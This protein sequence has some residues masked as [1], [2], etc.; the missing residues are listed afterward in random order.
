MNKKSIALLSS[1]L[2]GA[3]IIGGAFA[4]ITRW[5]VTDNANPNTAQITGGK[6]GEDTTGY[7]TL[8]WGTGTQLD[9]VEDMAD[10]KVYRVGVVNLVTDEMD[11]SRGSL[12][13][14]LQTAATGATKL[15]DY[16]EV[17][18]YEGEKD[19]GANNTYPEGTV[20]TGGTISPQH[21]QVSPDYDIAP[22]VTGKKT[23]QKYTIFVKLNCGGDAPTYAQIKNDVVYVR[24]DWN[25]HEDDVSTSNRVYVAKPAGWG[26]TFNYFAW[27]DTTHTATGDWPGQALTVE[28]KTRSGVQ[29]YYADIATSF[30]GFLFNDGTNQT[31]NIALSG[32]T[33]AKPAI[34]ID[35]EG[36]ATWIALPELDGEYEYRLIGDIGGV[37]HADE[38]WA[39]NSATKKVFAKTSTA[40]E[41][42]LTETF[43][44][45][46]EVKAVGSDDSGT[47]VLWF[48]A[49][50]GNY[51]ITKAG[52][53]NVYFRPAG[54]SDWGYYYLYFEFV[55]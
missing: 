16:L 45:N 36:K 5:A 42:K 39:W 28:S 1:V 15:V 20:I 50:G 55:A 6:L 46:D 49:E 31:E 10:G 11:Y 32:Y 38:N 35:G 34:A 22:A 7:V 19:L 2:S 30:E 37:A 54:N 51:K 18:V 29:Y 21:G 53:Y 3:L 47:T 41:Y 17:K 23:G 48:P 14:Q 44:L 27:N 24:V 4:S 13:V 9:N 43:S 40:G 26:S 8:T 25:A 52:Q 33:A 12:S